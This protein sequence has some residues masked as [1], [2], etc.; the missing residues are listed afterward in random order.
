VTEG[1]EETMAQAINTHGGSPTRATKGANL[2]IPFQ[3]KGHLIHNL[4]FQTS[5]ATGR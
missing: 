1:T 2:C 4:I 3:T 5:L